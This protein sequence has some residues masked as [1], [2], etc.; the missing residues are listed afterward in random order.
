MIW[1]KKRVGKKDNAKRIAAAAISVIFIAIISIG[2]ASAQTFLFSIPSGQPALAGATGVAVDG[3][4]NI[5]VAQAGVDQVVR[6]TPDG[7]EIWRIGTRGAG[8]G[9]FRHVI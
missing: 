2:T 1:H 5:Y 3:S 9:Q 6:L 8:S 7:S 4:G